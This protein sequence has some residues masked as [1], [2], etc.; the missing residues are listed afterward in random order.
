M[1]QRI[2]AGTIFLGS[3]GYDKRREVREKEK[4]KNKSIYCFGSK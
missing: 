2:S 3:S 4:R 1:W